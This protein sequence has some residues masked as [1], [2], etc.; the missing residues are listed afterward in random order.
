MIVIGFS[1]ESDDTRSSWSAFAV[2]PAARLFLGSP[3]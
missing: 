3:A 1:C 2:L